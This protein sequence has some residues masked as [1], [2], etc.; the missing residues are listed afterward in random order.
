MHAAAAANAKSPFHT[1]SGF[2]NN[3]PARLPRRLSPSAA[4]ATGRTDG[5]VVALATAT[6][7]SSLRG[8]R[9]DRGRSRLMATRDIYGERKWVH[10]TI[11]SRR[12][13]AYPAQHPES[14]PN[15]LTHSSTLSLSLSPPLPL[16]PNCFRMRHAANR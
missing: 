9:T 13:A 5:P 6:V 7:R 15:S 1:M 3:A 11:H 12:A 14:R 10:C 4:D 16:S 2:C 8:P